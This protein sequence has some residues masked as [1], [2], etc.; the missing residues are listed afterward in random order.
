V[1]LADHPAWGAAGMRFDVLLVDAAGRV[2]RII[3]AFRDE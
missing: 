1:V 3:D 2:R